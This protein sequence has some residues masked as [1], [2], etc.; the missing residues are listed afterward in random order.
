VYEAG[1]GI[2]IGRSSKAARCMQKMALLEVTNT[3]T[4]QHSIVDVHKQGDSS[5][6]SKPSENTS[7]NASSAGFNTSVGKGDCK[8][9][10]GLADTGRKLI[11][12]TLLQ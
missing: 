8:L 3:T 1:A 9:R 7:T 4:S 11:K 10:G 2:R 12:L 6:H 5:T